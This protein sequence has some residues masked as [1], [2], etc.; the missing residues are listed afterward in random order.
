MKYIYHSDKLRLKI[1]ERKRFGKPLIELN[2]QERGWLFWKTIEKLD[3]EVE[4]Y[5]GYIPGSPH[6][7]GCL[8]TSYRYG[9][10]CE[11]WPPD[12]F[13]LKKRANEYMA[14]YFEK[15]KERLLVDRAVKKQLESI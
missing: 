10:Y 2:I 9:G 13:D 3:I 1:S 14:E 12:I 15:N 11:T 8:R 4:Y 6:F 7:G 5:W